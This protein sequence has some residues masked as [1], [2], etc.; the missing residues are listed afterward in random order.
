MEE[1]NSASITRITSGRDL[2][3]LETSRKETTRRDAANR[4]FCWEGYEENRLREPTLEAETLLR[5]AENF[6]Q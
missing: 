3:R 6:S 5:L 2:E 4:L 1:R